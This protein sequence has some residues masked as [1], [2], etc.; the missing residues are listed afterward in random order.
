MEP[1]SNR[2]TSFIKGERSALVGYV[3]SLIGEAADRD[4]EDIVQDV[5]AGLFDRTDPLEPLRSVSAYVYQAIRNRVVDAFRSR[6]KNIPLDGNGDEDEALSLSETLHDSRFDTGAE[7]EAMELRELLVEAMD[8]L[9]DSERAV[10]VATELEGYSFRELSEL[11]E[12]PLGTLLAQKSRALAK[13]R[14]SII[15]KEYTNQ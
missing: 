1:R 11:W 3:R 13:L 10:V 14:E 8:R 12:V 9:G 7:I 6:K 2:I 4:G 15:L 5:M